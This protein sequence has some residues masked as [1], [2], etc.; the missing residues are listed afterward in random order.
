MQ[1][2]KIDFIDWKMDA[3]IIQY[4]CAI[5]QLVSLDSWLVCSV[6]IEPVIQWNM[7]HCD[8]D[9]AIPSHKLIFS[10]FHA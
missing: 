4:T 2:D 3:A 1:L 10:N 7:E 6:A 9:I 5:E 8:V